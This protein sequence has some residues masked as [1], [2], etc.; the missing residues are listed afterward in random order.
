M[1]RHSKEKATEIYNFYRTHGEKKTLETYKIKSTTLNRTLADFKN[2]YGN[3]EVFENNVLLE[4]IK[5]KYSKEEL[6]FIAA[7]GVDK[8]TI[9][10]KVID[11]DGEVFTF[12]HVSDT[13]IGGNC[14]KPEWWDACIKECEKQNIDMM[15]HTGDITE[16]MSNRAGNVY[17]LTHIGYDSQKEYA[18]NQLA[19]CSFPVY[20]IDG[21]HDR[22]Y[23]KSSGAL[24]VKDI[25]QAL[26]NVEFIGHDEG[27]V[28]INGVTIRLFHGEDGNSYAVSYRIQKVVESF[29]GG[30][31]PHVLLLGH[32]HKQCYL[33]D[34][35]IHCL[36][37]GACSSQSS[38]MRSKRIVNH[39][40]FWIVRMV[41]GKKG[42]CSFSPTWYPFYS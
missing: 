11:F 27:N 2:L 25:A 38:W 28:L 16:G 35:H 6:K 14:F 20:I 18:I 17:E 5:D 8:S 23:I 41:I 19:K 39:A 1:A 21:N 29:T 31:K 34:R 32:C 42:I 24:V 10:K 26:E 40:G 37:G 3:K 13:H 36:S 15:F 30:E 33:F 12:C 7:G 9:N 4:K 22:W